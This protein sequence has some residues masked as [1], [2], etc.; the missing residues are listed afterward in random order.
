M[1]STVYLK[2]I[3]KVGLANEAAL[4]FSQQCKHKYFSTG[5]IFFKC[6]KCY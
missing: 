6:P 4:I 2:L 5:S 1:N 3:A